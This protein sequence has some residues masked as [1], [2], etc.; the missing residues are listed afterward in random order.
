M[1]L[2]IDPWIRKLWY[3]LIKEDLTVVDA[4]IVL[5]DQK[6]PSRNDQ[7]ERM[8]KIYDFFVAM[9]EEHDITAVWIEKLFFTKSN[10]SNAE[11][12]FGI[13]GALAMLFQKKWIA[14]Y[15]W[16]PKEIKKRITWNWNAWKTLVQQFVQKLFRLKE[17]PEPHDAADA[18]GL[19]RMV[20]SVMKK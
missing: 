6:S 19:C 9:I 17:L 14:V 18:L 2:W 16:T 15:E 11:F 20:K 1:I 7:F 10:Q 3:A 12:V 5:H 8:E 4:G 13:R